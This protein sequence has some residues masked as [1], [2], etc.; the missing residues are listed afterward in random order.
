MAIK[1]LP[2]GGCYLLKFRFGGWQGSSQLPSTRRASL[3]TLR[4]GSVTSQI[5]GDLQKGLQLFNGFIIKLCDWTKVWAHRYHFWRSWRLCWVFAFSFCS[6]YS[7]LYDPLTHIP[8]WAGPAHSDVTI[9][10]SCIVSATL[11]P[12]SKV[13]HPPMAQLGGAVIGVRRQP[14]KAKP[15]ARLPKE[16]GNCVY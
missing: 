8:D 16:S 12:T 11:S 15:K 7:L 4:L 6:H 13:S 14:Y 10:T 1:Q 9:L 2:K 3:N 5:L